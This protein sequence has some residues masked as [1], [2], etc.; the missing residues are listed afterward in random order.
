MII[1]SWRRKSYIWND[2]ILYSWRQQ[3]YKK[4]HLDK[5]RWIVYLIYPIQ[6]AVYTTF[7]GGN[8]LA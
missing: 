3:V 6:A 7:G 5:K 2:N 1:N 4:Y 8:T